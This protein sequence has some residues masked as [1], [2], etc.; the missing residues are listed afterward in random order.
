MYR[1]YITD[2]NLEIKLLEAGFAI[3]LSNRENYMEIS[4]SVA[5]EMRQRIF[6]K[7]KPNLSNC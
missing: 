6:I 4:A 1:F 2:S 3:F 7:Q 5:E